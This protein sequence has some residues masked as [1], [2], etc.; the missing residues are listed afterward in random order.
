MNYDNFKNNIK[1][2]VQKYEFSF[3]FIN[4][5]DNFSFESQIC[6]KI[7][8]IEFSQEILLLLEGG[9]KENKE[10]KL[11]KEIIELKKI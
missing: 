2:L 8:S 5:I 1:V 6:D 4:F 9:N 10:N 7:I 3:K 11:N